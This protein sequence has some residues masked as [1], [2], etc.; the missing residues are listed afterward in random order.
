MP[1]PYQAELDDTRQELRRGAAGTV[2]LWPKVAGDNV[3]ASAA[4]FAVYEPDGTQ[5]AS[6]TS[7]ITTF[8]TDQASRIACAVSAV[9]LDLAENYRVDVTYTAGGV[10]Y[11]ESV[12]FDVLAEPMGTVQVSLNDLVDEV[13]DAAQILERLAEQQGANETDVR[14]AARLA[15]RGW[16][17]V[18]GWLRRDIRKAGGAWPAYILDRED[19]RPVIVAR[20]L[21]RMYALQGRGNATAAESADH[22]KAEADSRYAALPPIRFS[23]DEDKVETG[24]VATFGTIRMHRRWY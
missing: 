12:Q 8:D 4:T 9:G 6:G 11:V 17:D 2:V 21:H 18:R 23:D 24:E 13:A 7:T 3:V 14:L 10:D 5:L 16:G 19:L 15:L 20:A 22:W 1:S